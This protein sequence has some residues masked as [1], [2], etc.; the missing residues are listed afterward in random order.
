MPVKNAVAKSWAITPSSDGLRWS[1][2]P[3]GNKPGTNPAIGGFQQ[4]G[5]LDGDGVSPIST[6]TFTTQADGSSLFIFTAADLSTISSVSHNKTGTVANLGSLAYSDWA[7]FGA[8]CDWV[9][10]FQGGTGTVASA[11]NSIN[12]QREK[13]LFAAEVR[14]GRTVADIDIVEVPLAEV[15]TS[16]SVVTTGPAVLFSCWWGAGDV[17]NPMDC[18]LTS[19]A[20]ADGWVQIADYTIDS[21]A[22][23]QGALAYRVTTA[24]GTYACQWDHTPA[25]KAIMITLAVQA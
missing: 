13:T 15:V 12:P 23:I 6:P 9:Q 5:Q 25:Q 16:G 14:N 24:P 4:V 8:R 20:I 3:A 11:S 21:L 19:A 10:T 1:A 22:H 2:W 17:S 7:P 18:I